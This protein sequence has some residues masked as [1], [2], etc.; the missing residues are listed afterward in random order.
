M[1]RLCSSCTPETSGEARE[2]LSRAVAQARLAGRVVIAEHACFNACGM[3]MSIALQGTGRATY[4]FTGID[5]LAD[6]GDIV[7]TLRAYLD[8]PEG[9]IEDAGACGR[10]RH[11]LAGRVPAL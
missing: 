5:P 6:L 9:W 7:G 3:P 8:A 11:C 10:L 2:A 4:F 1:L